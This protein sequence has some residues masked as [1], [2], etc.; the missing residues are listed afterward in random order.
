VRQRKILVGAG[1]G[2]VRNA[3][4]EAAASPRG[5][6]RDADEGSIEALP[7]EDKAAV[8][9]L[10]ALVARVAGEL[11]PE[12]QVAVGVYLEAP[13]SPGAGFGGL[14][15]VVA[16]ADAGLAPVRILRKRPQRAT[17]SRRS[18]LR[19]SSK[20]DTHPKPIRDK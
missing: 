8:Q 6:E 3:R 4:R 16:Q 1:G 2:H 15:T 14:R 10:F 20:R 17:L 12:L 18:S 5:G 19:R 13:G 7:D 9:Q 11:A